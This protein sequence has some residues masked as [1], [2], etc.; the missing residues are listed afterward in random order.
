[1][2][3]KF[4]FVVAAAVGCRSAPTS[5]PQV[6]A[7]PYLRA[8]AQ[9]AYGAHQQF[10]SAADALAA[11]ASK[12]E[13][14]PSDAS[15]AAARAA[16][17]NAIDA[18]ETLEPMRIGPL[19]NDPSVGGSGL[20]ESLYAWT[21]FDR[22]KVDE[23]LVTKGFE[24]VATLLPDRRGLA[25]VEYLYFFEG[26]D[27]GCGATHPINTDGSW[28]AL[29]RDELGARKRAYAHAVAADVAAIAHRVVDAW[30]P[31]KGNFVG[32]LGAPNAK[33]PSFP[34]QQKAINA[35]S[36]AL[37]QIDSDTKDKKLAT[38]LGLATCTSSCSALVESRYAHRGQLHVRN[39]LVGARK[40]FAGCGASFD[41]LGFDDYLTARGATALGKE[42]DNG[43]ASAIVAVEAIG[44]L[45]LEDA[46][47]KN[48]ASVR[49]AY[50]AIKAVTD[51]M[52]TD[53]VSVLNL[54][55]PTAVHGDAD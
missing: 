20:H 1:M 52:K 46:I 19:S 42:L 21:L 13:S 18:W 36:N 2:H 39:N 12:L 55:L 15:L 37:F 33:D 41:G 9:C 10:A 5:R 7:T 53:F 34:T 49:A 14:A 29:S 4:L 45:P 30:D 8:W 51:T 44:P 3:L 43:V 17:T 38:P 50:D 16:W 11:A 54:D 47:A 22:C 28:T 6:D 31:T 40:L 27:N 32:S 24:P 48:P 23:L 25:S 26:I 35:V